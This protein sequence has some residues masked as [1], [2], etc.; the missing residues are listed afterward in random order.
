M[1]LMTQSNSKMSK[2]ALDFA[3]LTTSSELTRSFLTFFPLIP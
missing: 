1:S 3:K 2:F